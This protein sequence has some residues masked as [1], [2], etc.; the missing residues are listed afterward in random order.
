MRVRVPGLFRMVAR[1]LRQAAATAGKFFYFARHPEQETFLLGIHG[2][3][4]TMN[5][6]MLLTI[7]ST[8]HQ[9]RRCD[10][11][12]GESHGRPSAPETDDAK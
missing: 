7:L 11:G 1:T 5:T 12:R 4:K 9:N 10:P 8:I 2:L 6:V 3:A